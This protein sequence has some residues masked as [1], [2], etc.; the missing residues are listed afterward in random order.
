MGLGEYGGGGSV[1]WEVSYDNKNGSNVGQD[2]P[3]TKLR[4][5]GKDE[6]GGTAEGD[7]LYVICTN[8]VPLKLVPGT[9]IVEVTLA[10]KKDQVTLR[11]G[12][13]ITQD[14]QELSDSLHTAT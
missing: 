12:G 3:A 14:L 10:K 8:A 13:D 7:K 1:K 11:W 9:V 6:N 4:G 2:P 5:H